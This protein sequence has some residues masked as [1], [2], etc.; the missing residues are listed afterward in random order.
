MLGERIFEIL[1]L[2]HNH[3]PLSTHSTTPVFRIRSYL[4]EKITKIKILSSIGQSPS[5][6]ITYLPMN[7]LKHTL[8]KSVILNQILESKLKALDGKTSIQWLLQEFLN[9]GFARCKD[10]N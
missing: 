2:K 1:Q 10:L 7:N 4:D 5:Q 6:I 3:G 8:I 9:N